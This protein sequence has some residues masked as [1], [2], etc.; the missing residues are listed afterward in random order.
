MQYSRTHV[1]LLLCA[2]GLF[3]FSLARQA[4][5][6]S[7]LVVDDL[8]FVDHLKAGMI[9]QDV[10]VEMTPGADKVFRVTEESKDK[11]MGA[12]VFSTAQP[13]HHAPF[14]PDKIGPHGKGKTLGFTLGEWLA[15]T[16]SGTYS[17]RKGSGHVQATFKNLVPNGLY[18]M[19]Y[20]VAAKPHMGC[21][22]CP[23]AT[24]DLPVGAAD[25]SQ[26]PFTADASGNASFD[27]KFTPCLQLGSGNLMTMLAIAYHSDGNTYGPTPGPMGYVSHVQ[28]FVGLPEDG[29]WEM[30][31]EVK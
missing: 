25:G 12:K 16:G 4:T 11:F 18:T 9:E 31:E 19:W 6:D 10:Y 15:A 1:G 17:C 27:A 7:G 24:L 29:A 14:N 28:L 3:A 30:A 20:A 5:A 21:V 2:A 23:F 13:V 26:S 8:Q 22:D